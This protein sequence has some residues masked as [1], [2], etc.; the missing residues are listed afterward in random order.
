MEAR[1]HAPQLL[2]DQSGFANQDLTAFK[3]KSDY[4][5]KREDGLSDHSLRQVPT[6]AL[7]CPQLQTPTGQAQDQQGEPPGK[8]LGLMVLPAK[9]QRPAPT[10]PLSSLQ[11]NPSPASLNAY[12]PVALTLQCP[13]GL[14]LGHIKDCLPP[15]FDLHQ[16]VYKANRSTDS[17]QTAQPSVQLFPTFWSKNCP[18]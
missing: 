13:E 8:R 12:R 17:L 11:K 5:R 7:I 1:A 16:F 6:S 3:A 15:T 4:R 9:Q 2:S 10:S 14:V 18:I